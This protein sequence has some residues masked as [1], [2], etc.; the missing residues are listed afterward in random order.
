MCT[1][2]SSLVFF[3]FRIIL[4]LILLSTCG[5]ME[6]FTSLVFS[7]SKP[8]NQP[9]PQKGVIKVATA[10]ENIDAAIEAFTV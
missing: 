5:A 10:L 4:S 6:A 3:L 2:E 7:G 1:A 8:L 9:T